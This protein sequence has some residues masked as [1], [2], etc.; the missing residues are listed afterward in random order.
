MEHCHLVFFVFVECLLV[1]FDRLV[2]E[3]LLFIVVTI[4]Q[5]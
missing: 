3:T 2:N 5:L 4:V 1:A